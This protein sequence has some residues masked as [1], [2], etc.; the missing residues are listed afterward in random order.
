MVPMALLDDEKYN[1]VGFDGRIKYYDHLKHYWDALADASFEED[2]KKWRI[3]LRGYFSRTRPFIH[4][5][6]KDKITQQFR[7][8][9]NNIDQL[10]FT[11]NHNK[12]L[13]HNS[14]IRRLEDIQDT[15]FFATKDMLVTTGDDTDEVLSLDSFRRNAD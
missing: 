13:I 9:D 10:N 8:V 4:P 7:V 6:E 1:K 11:T 5:K 2:Y 12:E 14:I 15:L 3:A